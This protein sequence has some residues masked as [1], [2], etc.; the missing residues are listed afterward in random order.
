M[1]TAE[2][3]TAA[4]QAVAGCFGY[5]SYE[6]NECPFDCASIAQAALAA[7]ETIRL[8]IEAEARIQRDGSVRAA[9][10]AK[11]ATHLRRRA[12]YTI[13]DAGSDGVDGY[14]AAIML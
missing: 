9:E 4:S 2:E 5:A 13:R 1:P 10:R 7:A 11:W 8:P 12:N 3:L 14:V 6:V